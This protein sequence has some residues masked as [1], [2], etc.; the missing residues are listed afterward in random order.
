MQPRAIAAEARNLTAEDRIVAAFVFNF[1]KVV[2]WPAAARDTL[3]LAVIGDD[4]ATAA[5]QELDGRGFGSGSLR[6][7][8]RA[9]DGSLE[10]CDLLYLVPG[11]A[12]DLDSILAR[13]ASRPIL[14][15]SSA[16]EFCE[17]GGMVQLVSNRGKIRL[18]INN[19]RAQAANLVLSSQLLKMATI[20]EE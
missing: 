14:T 19:R 1:C 12:A 11:S 5:L 8:D 6:V 16:D 20:V 7:L 3:T 13:A 4:G 9:G 15:V 17:R 18:L 2:T 10:G